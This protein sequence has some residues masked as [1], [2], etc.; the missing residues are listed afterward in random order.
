MQVPLSIAAELHAEAKS[1]Q[2]HRD[3]NQAAG[4]TFHYAKDA[5]AA[6]RQSLGES[7]YR[8]SMNIKRQGDRARH[9]ARAR[10]W[11]PKGVAA[12]DP[13]SEEHTSK[14]LVNDTES[15]LDEGDDLFDA[16]SL[17]DGMCSCSSPIS[18][19]GG[20]LVQ[21]IEEHLVWEDCPLY[22]SMV[23]RTVAYAR[24]TVELTAE[25]AR[26]SIREGSFG[27]YVG[28][29]MGTFP[30]F[31]QICRVSFGLVEKDYRVRRLHD[32]T[33]RWMKQHEFQVVSFDSFAS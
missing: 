11:Q 30:V 18:S 13:A 21:G 25:H 12:V 28:F 16:F 9:F 24:R 32:G 19:C 15:S 22:T 20:V 5:A 29:G 7:H 6:T 33:E 10:G 3:N 2:R 17:L 23:D 31:G 1:L 27:D 4:R 8:D 26:S 14:V